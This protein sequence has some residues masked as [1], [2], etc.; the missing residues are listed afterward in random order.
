MRPAVRLSLCTLTFCFVSTLLF[1]EAP[2]VRLPGPAVSK[3]AAPGRAPEGRQRLR[4]G[5]KLTD[6]V[7]RFEFAG[8]RFAFHPN[9]GGEPMRV[10]ENLSLERVSTALQESRTK[11]DWVV[12]GTV[13]EF[14][15]NNYLIVTRAVTKSAESGRPTP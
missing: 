5:S 1:A 9:D 7:G 13:T 2:A 10:I 8:E 11:S 4:E 14:R 12:S 3:S 6:I 15:G